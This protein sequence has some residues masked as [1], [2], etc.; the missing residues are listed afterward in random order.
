M[1]PSKLLISMYNIIYKNYR[2]INSV[3]T[4]GFD[5]WWRKKAVLKMKRFIKDEEGVNILDCA[6]GCGDMTFHIKKV[7]K[8]AAIYAVDGNESML[9]IAKKRVSG[10]NFKIAVCDN[11]P[12]EDSYFD[13]I[14]VS[15]ATRNF[16]Y[17]CESK[18]IFSEFS[19]VLKKDG[20]FFS[21]ETSY[22]DNFFLA[23]LFKVYISFIFKILF[24]FLDNSEKAAYLFL[25]SS[26]LKFKSSDLE[27]KV[28]DLFII[29]EIKLFPYVVSLFICVKR[30]Y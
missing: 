16:Y 25:K 11:L 27:K 18:K 5:E 21:L 17:S 20:I 23:L 2:F 3:L 13:A 26:V 7:F 29:K 8:N 24:L 30:P 4:F 6:C 22:P 28:S 1:V 19:R 9:D 15:F 10:V 14:V 12:F